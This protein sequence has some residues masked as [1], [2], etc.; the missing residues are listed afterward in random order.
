MRIL[1][2]AAKH[3]PDEWIQQCPDVPWV[4]IAGMRNVVAPY[5]FGIEDAMVLET[6]RAHIPAVLPRLRN[7]LARVDQD[8]PQP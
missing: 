3:V 8:Y 7:I 4:R 6:V 2:E 5:Y 1:G